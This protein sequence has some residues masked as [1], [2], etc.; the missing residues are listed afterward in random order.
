MAGL[1][2]KALGLGFWVR[3]IQEIPMGT[4]CDHGLLRAASPARVLS[5][6]AG[7]DHVFCAE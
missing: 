3:R 2:S 7:R 4:V 5:V 6:T 1:L